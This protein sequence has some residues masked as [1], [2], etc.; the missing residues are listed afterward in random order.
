MVTSQKRPQNSP[1]YSVNTGLDSFILF[2]D[3]TFSEQVALTELM[4]NREEEEY[5]TELSKQFAKS[6][7]Y[8]KLNLGLEL[9]IIHPLLLNLE[10][11]ESSPQH[12]EKP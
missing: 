6:E 8:S 1:L 2:N 12:N 4:E 9:Q 10:I 7:N 3:E 11:Q 5:N